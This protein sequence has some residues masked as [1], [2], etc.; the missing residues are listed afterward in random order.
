MARSPLFHHHIPHMHM[1]MSWGQNHRS[2]F[3]CRLSLEKFEVGAKLSRYSIRPR[4]FEGE[5][6]RSANNSFLLLNF[7]S[8]FLSFPSFILENEEEEDK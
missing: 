1:K 8:F 3:H 7:L 4:G 6:E 5:R 2:E